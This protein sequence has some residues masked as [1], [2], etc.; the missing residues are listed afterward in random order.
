[1]PGSVT[2]V[3]LIGAMGGRALP[4][5]VPTLRRRGS[6]SALWD[7]I[8]VLALLHVHQ[9]ALARAHEAALLRSDPS[10]PFGLDLRAQL[11]KPVDQRLRPD[12]ASR[13]ENVRRNER[14]R[15]LHDAVGVVVRAAANRALA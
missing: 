12:R 15:A 10:A 11:Q 9:L 2:G 14:V 5:I 3:C 4:P 1:M 6:S 7:F 8:R 13:D